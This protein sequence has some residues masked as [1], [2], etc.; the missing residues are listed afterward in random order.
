[1]NFKGCLFDCWDT[2]IEYGE[3]EKNFLIKDFYDEYISE[4]T[5]KVVSK[6]EVVDVYRKFC[7]KYFKQY[8]FE[9]RIEA[10]F[11]YVMIYL[12]LKMKPNISLEEACYN[13]G[14]KHITKKIPD[15]DKFIDFLKKNDISY[16]VLSNTIHSYKMTMDNIKKCYD[17][18]FIFNKLL[19]SSDIGVKKPNTMIFDLGARSLNLKNEECIY[20][21]DSFLADVYGS[22]NSNFYKSVWLNWK[23]D[24]NNYDDFPVDKDKYVEV[25]SYDELMT[26]MKEGRF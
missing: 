5:K 11:Y 19:V 18:K 17:G 21:G 12:N 4:D 13:L 9:I 24:E 14:M 8:D 26:L 1:M 16:A 3:K 6:Q 20:I 25:S 23:K 10:I 15:C 7:D 22:S 2:I